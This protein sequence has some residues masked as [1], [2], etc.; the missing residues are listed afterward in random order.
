MHVLSKLEILTNKFVA[1]EHENQRLL[2]DLQYVN[3]EKAQQY[4]DLSQRVH[5]I[6]VT[7]LSL[8][9]QAS[10]AQNS[11]REPNIS[12]PTKFVARDM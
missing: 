1:L 5:Q 10:R 6:E 2:K 4:E 7:I 11:A 8:W 12:L 9:Q 3:I